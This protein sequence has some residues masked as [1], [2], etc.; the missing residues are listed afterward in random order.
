MK[1]VKVVKMVSES[2]KLKRLVKIVNIV[3]LIKPSATSLPHKLVNGIQLVCSEPSITRE[4]IKTNE[5]SMSY[6]SS[7]NN[8]SCDPECFS[9]HRWHS[10]NNRS[11]RNSCNTTQI[12]QLQSIHP[13]H[14]SQTL[15]ECTHAPETSLCLT[16]LSMIIFVINHQKQYCQNTFPEVYEVKTKQVHLVLLISTSC[17]GRL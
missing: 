11:S 13:I 16:K 4:A 7:N 9:W 17:C 2:L 14:T 1:Q 15:L 3:K 12:R 5:T 10:Y 6:N 8:Y